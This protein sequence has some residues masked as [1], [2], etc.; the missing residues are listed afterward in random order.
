MS[1]TTDA[2][3]IR[4][5]FCCPVCLF[6][7]FGLDTAPPPR[8]PRCDHRMEADTLDVP[9][10]RPSRSLTGRP[11]RPRGQN[12][13]GEGQGPP[14]ASPAPPWACL[15]ALR[16]PGLSLCV[17]APSADVMVASMAKAGRRPT[18]AERKA[19]NK[20]IWAELDRQRRAEWAAEVAKAKAP[21]P[22]PE[23]PNLAALF[24]AIR[25]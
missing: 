10:A 1:E 22:A 25:R 21:E 20:A 17:R 15:I 2:P 19:I 16:N 9:Q 18:R 7:R 23:K 12:E 5:E 24:R 4:L 13:A 11:G 8:C 14:S 6:S 3:P